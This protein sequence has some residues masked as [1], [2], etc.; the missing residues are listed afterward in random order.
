MF[1]IIHDRKTPIHLKI[2]S[3]F[4]IFLLKLEMYFIIIQDIKSIIF[5]VI[6]ESIL[7]GLCQ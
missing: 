3:L 2:I 5:I 4:V 6:Y 1:L 7:L